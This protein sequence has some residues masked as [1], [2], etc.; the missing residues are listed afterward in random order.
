[1]LTVT[2]A[3]SAVLALVAAG[4][5]TGIG[6]PSPPDLSLDGSASATPTGRGLTGAEAAQALAPFADSGLQCLPTG[7]E[8]W[9]L[10][11]D[12]ADVA[13]AAVGSLVVVVLDD[14]IVGL[15]P[16]TGE[17]AWNA[18]LE[19][20][21][22]PAGTQPQ[23]RARELLLDTRD[24]GVLIW[25]RRGLLQVRAADGT[26]RWTKLER[27]EQRVWTAALADRVVLTTGPV[28]GAGAT[29]H[30]TAYDRD[31]GRLRWSEEVTNV[32]HFAADL[33]AVRDDAGRPLRLDPATGA[34]S[35]GIRDRSGELRSVSTWTRDP[36][37]AAPRP[38]DRLVI[39]D[40]EG[41][42]AVTRGP[43]P[44]LVSSDPPV[45]ATRRGLLGVELSGSTPGDADV[46]SDG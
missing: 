14:G 42:W 30:V 38:P 9:A 28:R 31:D 44:R 13:P 29:Q 43:R 23:H 34:S 20:V 10:E 2:V 26:E 40:D 17:L 4:I 33:L 15:H 3:A 6:R 45:V 19:T 35:P 39:S 22:A 21:Q 46:A 32:D 25:S 8:R 27:R 12:V 16:A 11:A 5:G 37:D 36:V 24:D 41:R 18:D 1:V 7:C